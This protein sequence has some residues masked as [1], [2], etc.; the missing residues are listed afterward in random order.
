LV[1]AVIAS[2][3]CACIA[4]AVVAGTLT[5]FSTLDLSGLSPDLPGWAEG[6]LT[7]LVF[8]VGPGLA[9]VAAAGAAAVHWLN[10][11]VSRPPRAA[12]PALVIALVGLGLWAAA[13]SYAILAFATSPGGA[14]D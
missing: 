11:G 14:P 5:M 9:V 12:R 6:R 8:F 3:L 7:G 4:A 1:C 2:A 13:W 10:P